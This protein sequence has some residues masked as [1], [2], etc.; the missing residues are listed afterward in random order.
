MT[1]EPLGTVD[2]DAAASIGGGGPGLRIGDAEREAVAADLSEHFVAGRLRRDEL[3]ER[4][5]Q[6]GSARTAGD[7]R[8]LLIDLP[9]LRAT[10]QAAD[11]RPART[12][13][14]ADVDER[15]P[16]VISYVGVNTSLWIIWAVIGG[17]ASFPWPLFPTLFWGLGLVLHLSGGVHAHPHHQAFVPERPHHRDHGGPHRR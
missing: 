13:G 5:E 1:A 17:G 15:R 3:D 11:R 7:L 4:L 10:V 16:R 12:S 9:P 8:P 2:V 14:W 6:A